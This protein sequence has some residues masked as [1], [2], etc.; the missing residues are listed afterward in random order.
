[1]LYPIISEHI[2]N[3]R[4][5]KAITAYNIELSDTSIDKIENILND[6]KLFNQ[7]ILKLNNRFTDFEELSED[8][9]QTLRIGI[10]DIVAYI[11]IPAIDVYLPIYHGTEKSVLQIGVGHMEGT[12]LPIGGNGTHCVLSGHTGLPSAKLFNDLAKMKVG[13]VFTIHILKQS[14]LYKVEQINVVLPYEMELLAIQP[15]KDLVTLLTCTPYGSNTHRLL[16]QGKRIEDTNNEIKISNIDDYR[17]E[18]DELVNFPIHVQIILINIILVIIAKIILELR[19]YRLRIKRKRKKRKRR[20]VFNSTLS[21][22][23]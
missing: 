9:Y 20:L 13:D 22:N 4:Q 15:N 12:S 21:T 1:M 10:S 3:K 6:A 5:T 17:I 8:Y 2:N 16:V 7:K 11:E 23:Q 14:L 19:I 18:N